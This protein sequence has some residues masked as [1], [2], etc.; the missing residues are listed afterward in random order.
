MV[1]N[2]QHEKCLEEYEENCECG[3]ILEESTQLTPPA[4]M[5]TLKREGINEEPAG[6]T[7]ATGSE[8][9]KARKHNINE[10]YHLQSA[11]DQGLSFTPHSKQ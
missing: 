2:H 7:E 8:E 11:V 3:Q 5:Q 1:S 4:C 6:R 10:T 9:G